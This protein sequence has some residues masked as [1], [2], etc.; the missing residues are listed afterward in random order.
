LFDLRKNV[1]PHSLISLGYPAEQQPQE[2]RYRPER[3]HRNA[4]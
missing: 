2:E 1:I 3:I 4:W